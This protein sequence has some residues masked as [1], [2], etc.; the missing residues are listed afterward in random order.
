[1]SGRIVQADL[2]GV[3]LVAPK[4]VGKALAEKGGKATGSPK[5]EDERCGFPGCAVKSYP[6]G[7]RAH[8]RNCD[9]VRMGLSGP[10]CH[11][12]ISRSAAG[13]TK[14]GV[15]DPP[16]PKRNAG[17]DTGGP[18]TSSPQA[19]APAVNPSSAENPGCRPNV[20]VRLQPMFEKG[21]WC[22]AHEQPF[23]ACQEIARLRDEIEKLITALTHE[24]FI[25][26][27]FKASLKAPFKMSRKC[28]V[29]ALVQEAQGMIGGKE[30][31]A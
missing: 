26:V 12:F 10:G 21:M 6:G 17:E 14:A 19:A 13:R 1:M 24:H 27:G 20:N 3:R 28:S 4:A 11:S 23:R 22:H 25:R 5:L 15:R 29:C 7:H 18:R 16:N 8:D 2:E 31:R 30:D 9:G